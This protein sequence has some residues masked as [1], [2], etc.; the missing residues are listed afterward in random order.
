MDS[1]GIGMILGRYKLLKSI[2]GAVF[3]ENPTN[4]VIKII[5]IAGINKIIPVIFNTDNSAC[6]VR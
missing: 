1:S 2:G 3:I 4:A 5:E 6:E